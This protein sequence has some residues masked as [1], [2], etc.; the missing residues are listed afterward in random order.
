MA[1]QGNSLERIHIDAIAQSS[2]RRVPLDVG[3]LKAGLNGAPRESNQNECSGAL[4][5]PEL[6]ALGCS[7]VS[8]D[9]YGT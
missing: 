7:R 1:Y 8:R 9:I 2:T 6:L 5:T 3:Y 4:P